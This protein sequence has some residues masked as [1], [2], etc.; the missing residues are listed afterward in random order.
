MEP[1]RLRTSAPSLLGCPPA[2]RGTRWLRASVALGDEWRERVE[3]IGE[4]RDE[5]LVHE[6]G[7]AED[8]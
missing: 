3:A 8:V 4:E 5:R 1:I 2:R 6:V 7:C